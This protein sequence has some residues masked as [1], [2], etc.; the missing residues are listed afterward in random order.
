MI[1]LWFWY[2]V[3]EKH[4]GKDLAKM[5]V[6]CRR[7]CI[8]KQHIYIKADTN[9]DNIA[10]IKIFEKMAILYVGWYI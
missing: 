2:D 9:F 4:L 5:I 3:S 6:L 8:R 7:F 10:M 1:L